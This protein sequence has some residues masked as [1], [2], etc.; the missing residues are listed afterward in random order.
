[1]RP[2]GARLLD[3]ALRRGAPRKLRRAAMYIAGGVL[4]L[5]S[6]AGMSLLVD[7]SA[8]KLA[9]CAVTLVVVS[10]L[11]GGIIAFVD[12]S[13]LRRVSS[14]S[15]EGLA[16]AEGRADDRPEAT[17]GTQPSASESTRRD[18][19]ALR[20]ASPNRSAWARFPSR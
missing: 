8:W 2:V 6:A 3:E 1:M 7:G 19:R 9:V 18:D 15:T 16:A 5:P 20:N 12:I 13:N 4:A 10:L 14:R 17:T 11:W